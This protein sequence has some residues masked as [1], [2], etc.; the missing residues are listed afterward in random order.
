MEDVKSEMCSL[1]AQAYNLLGGALK[2]DKFP[3]L[4]TS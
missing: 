2:T 3:F 1:T 4:A